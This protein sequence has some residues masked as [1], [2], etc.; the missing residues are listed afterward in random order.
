MS[1]VTAPCSGTLANSYSEYGSKR[2][3]SFFS[4]ASAS[5]TGSIASSGGSGSRARASIESRLA[6]RLT[7][8]NCSSAAESPSGCEPIEPVMSLGS[9]FASA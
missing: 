9:K 2:P 1:G 8:G 3:P 5:G 6:L 7:L 4:D